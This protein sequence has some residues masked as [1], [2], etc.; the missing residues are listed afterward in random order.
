MLKSIQNHLKSDWNQ[1]EIDSKSI[2]I[3]LKSIQNQIEMM[4]Q[5]FIQKPDHLNFHTIQAPKIV[6][7]GPPH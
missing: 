3:I 5:H 7:R 1:T 4:L 6:W 2:V